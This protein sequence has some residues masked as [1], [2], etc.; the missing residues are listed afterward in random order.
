MLWMVNGVAFTVSMLVHFIGGVII[1]I[2]A[3]L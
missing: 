1:A 2:L 3:F